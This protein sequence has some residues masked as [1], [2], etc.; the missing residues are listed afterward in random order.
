MKAAGIS[1]IRD[2]KVFIDEFFIL[3]HDLAKIYKYHK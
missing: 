1:T 2:I 3:E